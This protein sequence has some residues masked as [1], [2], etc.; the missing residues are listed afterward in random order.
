MDK[1]CVDV[2]V[3]RMS[4]GYFHVVHLCDLTDRALQA[5]DSILSSTF[6]FKIELLHQLLHRCKDLHVSVLCVALQVFIADV[7]VV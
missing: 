2:V 4:V 6:R 3:V 7:S 1:T 5:F